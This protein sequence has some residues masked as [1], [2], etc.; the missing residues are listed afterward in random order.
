[1]ESRRNEQQHERKPPSP[2]A[3]RGRAVSRL[4]KQAVILGS[5]S[6]DEELERYLG[7]TA[8]RGPAREKASA[9]LGGKAVAARVDHPV[10]RQRPERTRQR[11][12]SRGERD[13]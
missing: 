3:D 6:R 10:D 9:Q 12:A 5:K 13:R 8:L 1:M 7:E 2:E 4:G 11:D